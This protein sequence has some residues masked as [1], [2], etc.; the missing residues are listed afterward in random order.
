[1]DP[2]RIIDKYGGIP[3]WRHRDTVR[4]STDTLPVPLL[5]SEPHQYCHHLYILRYASMA[6]CY[7]VGVSGSNPLPLVRIALAW[8]VNVALGKLSQSSNPS[9]RHRKA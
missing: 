6:S 7:P 9:Y 8:E 5:R 1:M 3:D 4:R 2:Q